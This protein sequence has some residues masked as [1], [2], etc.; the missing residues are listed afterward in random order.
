MQAILIKLFVTEVFDEQKLIIGPGYLTIF[1]LSAIN[2]L[3]IARTH[4]H[5]KFA[6]SLNEISSCIDF[7]ISFFSQPG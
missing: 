3:F 2:P 5:L 7:I 4:R 6:L 1:T